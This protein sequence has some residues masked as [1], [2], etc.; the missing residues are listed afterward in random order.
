M[1]MQDVANF[2]KQKQ[3]TLTSRLQKV[4]IKAERPYQLDTNKTGD[5]NLGIC[6]CVC[7]NMCLNFPRKAT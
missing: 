2:K 4:L 6:V 5:T 3:D 7:M 1:P